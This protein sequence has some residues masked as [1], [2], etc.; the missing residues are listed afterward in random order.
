MTAPTTEANGSEMLRHSASQH[1][2]FPHH[3]IN[4]LKT[5]RE[6]AASELEEYIEDGSVSPPRLTQVSGKSYLEYADR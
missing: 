5:K 6:S 3:D 2:D 4:E 1:R